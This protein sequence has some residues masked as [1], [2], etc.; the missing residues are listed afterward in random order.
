MY[1]LKFIITV[2]F[3]CLFYA[4]PTK[5]QSNELKATLVY[6]IADSL[7]KAGNDNDARDTLF[8]LLPSFN[9]INNDTLESKI[10][11]LFGY[12]QKNIGND[13]VSINQFMQGLSK[14]QI[15]NYLGAIKAMGYYFYEKENYPKALSYFRKLL[16]FSSN[17]KNKKTKAEAHFYL[18]EV[19]FTMDNTIK[20]KRYYYKALDYAKKTNNSTLY[21][22]IY[23]RLGEIG[24]KENNTDTAIYYY[25]KTVE[26]AKEKFSHENQ[27]IANSNLSKIMVEKGNSSEAI[28]YLNRA[29]RIGEINN[30][31]HL[32]QLYFELAQIFLH[33]GNRKA[34]LRYY[35][36]S[37]LSAKHNNDIQIKIQSAKLLGRINLEYGN[38]LHAAQYLEEA[39]KQ[40]DS[41]N[42]INSSKDLARYEAQYDL[43]QKEQEIVLLDRDKRLNKAELNNQKLRNRFYF[44]GLIILAILVGFLL[45]HISTRIKKNKL[46]SSQNQKIY[47]QNEE[48]NQINLQLSQ[49][50]Q[51]LIQALSVK[52]KLFTIIG[53]DL[54]S[55]LLDI[56]NLIF[57]LKNNVNQF[58]EDDLKNHTAQI[59]NRLISL[60]E[61]LNN[62]LNWGMAE[63][64]SLKY[65]P[66]KI[67][68]NNLVDKTVKLFEG[69]ILFKK[70][71]IN[72]QIPAKQ[73]W[74][75]DHNMLEFTLR[76]IISNAIKFS[77]VE[78]SISITVENKAKQ[79]CFK[80]EDNGIGMDTEQ[81]DKIYIQTSEKVR[82]GTNNEKGTGLGMTLAHEFTNQMKGQILIDSKQHKGTKVTVI[83]PENGLTL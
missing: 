71:K 82:R 61:L 55:P 13:T 52:N 73:F 75:T 25:T 76:N 53:H 45:F 19:F 51:K 59:E 41:L 9:K 8:A 46:L 74:T 50:E 11:A 54:K 12:M 79:L 31:K 77:P 60:L 10:L 18:G 29:I 48:L 6:K 40:T 80:I 39:I 17:V 81:L 1:K 3:L 56:K 36:L 64:Q 35:K 58:S 66:E 30:S 43:M 37:L 62:L 63:K 70:L 49:S 44:G 28:T 16:L 34:A 2:G 27:I 68:I 32:P 69:Q 47:E 57:I 38:Y 22:Q 78:S 21:I 4:H 72:S 14:K 42:Q 5:A 33:A 20:A 67:S 83:L 7:H 24:R 15:S 26:I 65:T 23:S